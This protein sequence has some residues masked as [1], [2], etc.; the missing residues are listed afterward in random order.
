MVDHG[1]INRMPVRYEQRF[2]IPAQ[3]LEE[4]CNRYGLHELSIFG[5]AL[6][7][8]FRPDS[9][10]DVLVDLDPGV[11]MTIELFLAIRDELES[12]FGRKVDLVQKPLLRNPYRRGEILRTREILYAA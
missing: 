9:D 2:N 5:S 12:L 3:A 8:D 6:R 10:V 11:I 7:E 1:R 4:L